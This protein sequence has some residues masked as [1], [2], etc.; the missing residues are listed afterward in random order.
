MK[1]RKEGRKRGQ[2]EGR[3]KRKKGRK[4]RKK[5]WRK[6]GEKE[7]R[8][9]GKEGGSKEGRKVC[10]QASCALSGSQ[11]PSFSIISLDWRFSYLFV[12]M[13]CDFGLI[14]FSCTVFQFSLISSW[15]WEL[16]EGK[17]KNNF[18]PYCLFH[19]FLTPVSNQ[20]PIAYIL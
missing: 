19:N 3:K 13:L 2:E 11:V 8:K 16:P 14:F 9:E 4:E 15:R 12:C 17:I 10:R 5:E 1:E 6:E 7:A 18:T 20:P